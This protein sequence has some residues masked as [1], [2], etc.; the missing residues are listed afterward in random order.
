MAA[1][2]SAVADAQAG[3]GGRRSGSPAPMAGRA[4]GRPNILWLSGL[5][6][7]YLAVPVAVFLVRS[8]GAPGQGFSSPGLWGAVA[9]SAEAATISAGIVAVL[10][11]P[12]AYLLARSRGR[13]GGIAALA[14]QLPLALPPLMS[15]VVLLY[16]VGPG[17]WLGRLTGGWFT[18]SLAGIVL[19]QCF[20]AAPFLVV[21]ARSAFRA[22]NPN[23]EDI[24]AT[25]GMGALARF[26]R[27]AVPLASGGIRAG[28]VLTWLRAFGEYG[29]T[30]MLAYHPYSLPVFTYVQ[31]SATGLPA[32][33]APALL[34]LALAAIVVAASRAPHLRRPRPGA[35]APGPPQPATAPVTLRARPVPVAFDIHDRAGTFT[36]N[37]AYRASTHR[38]AILGPSGAGKSLTLRALGGLAPGRVWFGDDEVSGLPAERRSAGYVPQGA[39]LL[40]HLSAWANMTLGPRAVPRLAEQWAALLGIPE[41][42]HRLPGQLSGGQAQRVAIGRALSSEPRVVLLDEPFTGLDAPVR[43]ALV[44]QLRR[45]QVDGDLS[46]VLVTHDFREAALLADEVVVL[47][48]GRVLQAGAV[49]DVARSPSSPDVAALTGARNLVA[50]TAAGPAA[51][52]A[53]PGQVLA[54]ARHGVAPG[55]ALI[56]CARPELLQMAT[57]AGAGHAAP[58][59]IQGRVL[60]VVDLGYSYEV[61]VG[62]GDGSGPQLSVPAAHR[63]PPAVGEVV[64]LSVAPDDVMVW[65]AGAVPVA[66][67]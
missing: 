18:E 19:A 45:L 3:M 37:V 42:H 13:L 41:L 10:G 25:A 31:F 12:L 40:P 39:N 59:T 43:A 36:L 60:D 51:V 55:A 62:L 2:A 63:A 4:K 9:T 66:R 33:Q 44:E 8:A 14:V 1:P 65:P 48:Q 30:V 49:G 7:A 53:C 27:V 29:A 32:T 5:L 21:A 11:V 47:S 22:V 17:T 20:V 58:G 23:F 57:G 50:G 6:L 52:L 26:Y 28:L 61:T 56:W 15:G 54:T 16:V 38:L 64:E 34:A 46:T 67:P 24:A 35:W